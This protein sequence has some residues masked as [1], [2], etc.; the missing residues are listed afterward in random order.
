MLIFRTGKKGNGKTLNSIKELDEQGFAQDR[1]IYYHNVTGLKPELLKASWHEFDDP[2][3]WFELPQNSIILIDEAQGWF[4]RDDARAPI[5]PHLSNIEIMRKQGFEMHLITQDPRFLHSHA[6]RLCDLHIHYMRIFKSSQLVRFESQELIEKVE[7][8]TS[9]KDADKK[10]LKLD[11]KYFGV[12]K[13]VADGAAHHFKTKIPVKF[14]LALV[15][16]LVA[17]YMASRVYDRFQEGTAPLTEQAAPTPGI[18]DQAKGAIGSF[19]STNKPETSG[20]KTTQDYLTER[21]PR[22][23]GLP[24][25]A[26][27][28]DELTKPVSF[29]KLYC[30]SSSDPDI[31][32]K[33]FGSRPHGSLNGRPTV[34]QC[35]TQQATVIETD[36]HFCITVVQKRHF[37]HTLPDRSN[38][39]LA[40]N[41]PP[42]D[43]SSTFN[44]DSR[45]QEKPSVSLTV[46]PYEKGRFLW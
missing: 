9:F 26:P 41:N 12:Y 10:T 15:V 6:R 39:Q 27:V 5:P 30:M 13:S 16:I 8:K 22:L 2:L 37:D 21:L 19:I 23:E 34:C 20:S 17:A 3:K 1:P 45:A 32:A 46:V 33:T 11:K 44:G 18:V 14:I 36:F 28:Y 40:R 4:G 24:S 29:P 7:L 43:R 38:D 31:Y 42:V 35:Y 25:S